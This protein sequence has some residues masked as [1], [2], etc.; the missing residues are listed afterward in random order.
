MNYNESCVIIGVV[1]GFCAKMLGGFDYAMKIL[2]FFMVV[3][4]IAGFVCAAL[5][6][7]SQYAK[8]GV[9]STA[10]LRGAVRKISILSI[11]AIGV[12]I[13]RIIET[14][15]VRNGVVMYFIATEGISILEHC[16][17][18]GIPVPKFIVGLLENIG[19]EKEEKSNEAETNTYKGKRLKE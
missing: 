11:V 12:A 1:G 5:F 19:R 4:I 9:S 18:M 6:N 10:L 2:I 8:N 13:D 7:C 17:N 14:D 16:V 3:D 15:Y